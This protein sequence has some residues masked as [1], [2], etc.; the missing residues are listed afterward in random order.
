MDAG[1]TIASLKNNLYHVFGYPTELLTDQRTCFTAK[2]STV[3]GALSWDTMDFPH[4][5]LLRGQWSH[6]TMELTQ[7][8]TK[9]RQIYFNHYIPI[10][11]NSPISGGC[12]KDIFLRF[13]KTNRSGL[14]TSFK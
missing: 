2:T 3:M 7:T 4:T 6:Q 9:E 14:K 11:K 8:A 13:G 10:P 12:L 1:S 5:L